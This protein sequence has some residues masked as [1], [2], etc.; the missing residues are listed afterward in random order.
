M[1][2]SNRSNRRKRKQE[3]DNI[4]KIYH[5]ISSYNIQVE[6]TY[7]TDEITSES[8]K[9]PST[10]TCLIRTSHIETNT[11]F[12]EPVSAIPITSFPLNL[13]NETPDN[14]EI[15]EQEH[16]TT[17]N[18]KEELSTWA[19]ECNVPNITVNKLLKLMKKNEVINTNDLPN[20]CRTLL[21]T[22]KKK[23]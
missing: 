2:K 9:I 18:F 20:D 5:P 7:N 4:Q 17:N 15:I 11:F 3:L 8:Q 21:S 1:I 16:I 10:S 23:S 12:T 14:H 6:P 22:P 19:I 13:F